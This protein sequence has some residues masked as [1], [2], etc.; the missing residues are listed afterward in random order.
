MECPEEH[1]FSVYKSQNIVGC[2][3]LRNKLPE[4]FKKSVDLS[5]S[6]NIRKIAAKDVLLIDSKYGSAK[7]VFRWSCINLA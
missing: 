2:N 3:E 1:T 7:R 5:L 4:N 6:C